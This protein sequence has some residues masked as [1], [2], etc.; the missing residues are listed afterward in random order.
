M[1]RFLVRAMRRK[2]LTTR[3]IVAGLLFFLFLE[4]ALRITGF[5]Y[6][7]ATYNSPEPKPWKDHF[8]IFCLGESTTAGTGVP[9]AFN[10]PAQLTALLE[11]HRPDI[12]FRVIH[13]N[14]VSR[15][16]SQMLLDLPRLIATYEPDLVIAMVGANNWSNTPYR[17]RSHPRLSR[18]YYATQGALLHLSTY[19]L[20]R[21]LYFRVLF[22]NTAND[23]PIPL[24]GDGML[25]HRKKAFV[26]DLLERDL[27]AMV[28]MCQARGIDV[29]IAG[30]PLRDYWEVHYKVAGA[31]EVPFADTAAAFESPARSGALEDYLLAD[32]WHPNEKGYAILAQSLFDALVTNDLLP[33]P[34][35]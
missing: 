17:F 2:S 13:D 22:Y 18:F 19:K 20:F 14:A 4:I 9:F 30:Y 10:Y 28:T 12:R 7:R 27:V 32:R 26:Y 15:H 34:A 23:R 24:Y 25:I 1:Q 31:T 8:T 6:K 3:L 5:A 21:L 33:P 11:G 29:M 35:K 16:T